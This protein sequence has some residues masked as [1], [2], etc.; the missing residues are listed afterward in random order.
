[1]VRFQRTAYAAGVNVLKAINWAK[2]VTEF[3]NSKQPA[4]NLKTF[5][6]RF[7]EYGVI[8]WSAD[9]EDFPALDSWIQ[10]IQADQGYWEMLTK[11]DGL[12]QQGRGVD[13]VMTS[14]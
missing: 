5:T 9:F 4:G 6:G 8:Y 10:Q 12:F 7:G 2:E 3:I 14:V 1:M 11:A 13:V